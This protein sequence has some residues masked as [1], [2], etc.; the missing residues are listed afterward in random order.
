MSD[1]SL[2]R[3]GGYCLLAGALVTIVGVFLHAPQPQT[4]A[5]LAGGDTGRWALSHWLLVIG[6]PLLLAGFLALT[7]HFSGGPA[8]GLAVLAAALL[9]LATAGLVAV[10]GPEATMYPRV[11]AAYAAG[12]ESAAW[13]QATYPALNA[14]VLG[15]F[16]AFAPVFWAGVALVGLSLVRGGGFPVWLGWSG[17]AVGLVLAIAV[18]T[19]ESWPVSQVLFSVGYAWIAVAGFL[20]AGRAAGAPRPAQAAGIT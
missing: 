7:R 11:A 6:P 19:V 13:A 16:L 14:V 4:A 15:L 3:V 5:E 18:F 10:V 1:P 2:Y 20:F 17:V 12:G 8:E 9:I